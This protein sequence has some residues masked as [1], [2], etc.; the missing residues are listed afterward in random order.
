M[1]PPAL[2]TWSL[3][4]M[5]DAALQPSNGLCQFWEAGDHSLQALARLAHGSLNAIAS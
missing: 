2:N 4:L 3:A 5:G 1:E